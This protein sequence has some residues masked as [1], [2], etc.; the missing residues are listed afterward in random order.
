MPIL[1]DKIY[2]AGIIDGDGCISIGCKRNKK[3]AL[4]V[5]VVNTNY[6]LMKYLK[7]TWGGG[8]SKHTT[9][10]RKW[11][12]SYMWSSS[13]INLSGFLKE[14]SPYLKLKKSK[15][16]LALS[17]GLTRICVRLIVKEKVCICE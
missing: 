1:E 2:T 15:Q 13:L 4:S 11:K 10:R 12:D 6:N 16:K 3:Y 14:I 7:E 8:I 17:L 5:Q 9:N